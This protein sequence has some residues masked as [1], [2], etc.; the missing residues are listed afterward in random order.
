MSFIFLEEENNLEKGSYEVEEGWKEKQILQ[1]GD[2]SRLFIWAT[3]PDGDLMSCPLC[4]V[5]WVMWSQW[6]Y[7]SH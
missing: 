3:N 2:I 6:L 7:P 5:R 1:D 4:G